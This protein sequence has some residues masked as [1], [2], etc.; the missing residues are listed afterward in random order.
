MAKILKKVVG[1]YLT[2]SAQI[3]SRDVNAGAHIHLF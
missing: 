1:W 3:Y 2:S